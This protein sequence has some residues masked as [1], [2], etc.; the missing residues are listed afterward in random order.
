MFGPFGRGAALVLALAALTQPAAAGIVTADCTGM[1]DHNVYR[2]DPAVPHQDIAGLGPSEVAVDDVQI[3]VSGAYGEYR[4]DLQ[5][6]TLYHNGRDT[7][8]Y[9]T[10]SGIERP[11]RP[12]TP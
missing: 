7:S 1:V 6:G 2:F 8:L 11:R 3:R 9:C 5:V 4:F 12:T 10:Y